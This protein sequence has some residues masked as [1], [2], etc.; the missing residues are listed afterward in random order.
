MYRTLT[1]PKP[2]PPSIVTV[3][4]RITTTS[5]EVVKRRGV[6]NFDP[7]SSP[8]TAAVALSPSSSVGRSS[9]ALRSQGEPT[10]AGRSRERQRPAPSFLP[11]TSLK[12]CL[13]GLRNRQR[14]RWPSG[15]GG[16]PSQLD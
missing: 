6:K 8:H 3:A 10:A 4:R 14:R 13:N 7:P 12:N 15:S 5:G 9:V 2:E 1:L 16:P 11:R